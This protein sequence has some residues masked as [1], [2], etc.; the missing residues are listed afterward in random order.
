I[1]T[2][3]SLMVRAPWSEEAASLSRGAPELSV[4][5]HVDLRISEIAPR[6]RLLDELRE[7][8][9]RFQE[10]IGRAPTHIDSH[11]NVHRDRAARPVFIEFAGQ[12]GLPLREHSSVRYFSQFYGQWGGQTHLEQIS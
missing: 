8:F 2:G 12:R 10:L 5:L 6:L 9:R 1:L 3:T 4:G 7:Q 11:H